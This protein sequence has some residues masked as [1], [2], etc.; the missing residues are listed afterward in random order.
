MSVN[1]I[2]PIYPFSESIEITTTGV[3]AVPVRRIAAGEVITRLSARIKTAAVRAAGACNI[4]VGD[5]DAADGYLVAA[6]AKASAGTVYGED[7][8][9]RGA[10]MYDATK[11]GSFYKLYAAEGKTIKAVL[12]A[13]P[14]TE[15]VVQVLVTGFR[16]NLG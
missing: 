12:S 4:T 14:D 15:A 2:R 1:T 5:D 8:T 10:Y 16:S 13:A 6:D 7:P 11:K 3:T 9:A